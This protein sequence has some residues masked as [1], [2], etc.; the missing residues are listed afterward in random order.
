M[1]LFR[2]TQ[3]LEPCSAG[4]ASS[5]LK[6]NIGWCPKL[7]DQALVA[8]GRGCTALQYLYLLGNPNMTMDG[9]RSLAAGCSRLVGMDVCGLR[10][11]DRS[12]P[13]LQPLF[14]ALTSLAK[15]GQAPNYDDY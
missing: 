6:L 13:A 3:G 9:L 5:L 4:S 2:F 15:L 1:G 12:M 10:L 14:P 11:P 8:L 7:T